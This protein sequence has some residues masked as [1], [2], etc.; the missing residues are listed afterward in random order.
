MHILKDM[1]NSTMP[2]GTYLLGTNLC[3]YSEFAFQTL[4]DMYNNTMA[5]RTCLLGTNLYIYSEFAFPALDLSFPVIMVLLLSLCLSVSYI[6]FNAMLVSKEQMW[7]INL[8]SVG[9]ASS[10]SLDHEKFDLWFVS[11]FNIDNLQ[12]FQNDISTI[13]FIV[14]RKF[15]P[16]FL[17]INKL[18]QQC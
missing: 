7:G 11:L 10:T 12:F 18:L 6:V 16:N 1:H 3:I 5:Y 13:R 17:V 14:F 15:F 4:K 9:L 8:F 2:Y